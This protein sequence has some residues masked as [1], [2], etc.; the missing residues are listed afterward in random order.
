M[1]NRLLLPTDFSDISKNALRYSQLF[2]QTI[3]ADITLMHSCESRLNRF[4]LSRKKHEAVYHQLEDFARNKDGSIPDNIHFMV[5][6]GKLKEVI[7]TA[8]M[9]GKFRYVIIGKKHSYNTFPKIKG[10]KTS[11]LFAN[12]HCPVLVVPAGIGFNGIN[13][14]LV[15]G[16]QYKNM[17]SSIQENILSLSLNFGANLHYLSFTKDPLAWEFNQEILN[18]ENVL[19]QKSVPEEIAA[20]STLDYVQ[21]NAIDL[22]IMVRKR[23]KAFENLFSYG[24]EQQCLSKIDI[25]V[26]VFHHNFLQMRREKE[27]ARLEGEAIAI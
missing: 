1:M 4:W 9:A 25:P 27:K 3:S 23:R 5:R 15:V 12:A 7:S 16:G 21:D 18:K 26:M 14:I 11:Q 22:L 10:T 24:F 20:E 8:C 19:I 6:R 17:D 2:A 13:N